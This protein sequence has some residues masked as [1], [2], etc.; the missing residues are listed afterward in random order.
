MAA[1]ITSKFRFHNAEQFKES[2]SEDAAEFSSSASNRCGTSST[3]VD[4]I[5][6]L[7]PPFSQGAFSC[8]EAKLLILPSMEKSHASKTMGLIARARDS[9]SS[10][11]DA[12]NSGDMGE[13]MPMGLAT[14]KRWGE[15]ATTLFDME[16]FFPNMES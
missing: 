9:V 12:D 3:T 4:C 1:I 7:T 15:L 8:S 16:I 2:F 5:G 10:N 14:P 13:R 6:W 11:G